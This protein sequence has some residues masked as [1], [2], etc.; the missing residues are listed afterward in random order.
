MLPISGRSE[1]P[2]DV[3]PDYSEAVLAYHSKHYD[4]ALDILNRLAQRLP[5]TIEI[6]ELKALISEFEKTYIQLIES[7]R[8]QG[9]P[10]NDVAPYFF[11]LGM[12]HYRAK[13]YDSAQ[14]ALIFSLKHGFNAPIAH[15]YLGIIATIQSDFN[16]A[17]AHFREVFRQDENAEI[18]PIAHFYQAQVCLK[19]GR[20]GDAV[21]R[22][23]LAKESAKNIINDARYPEES[24]NISRAILTASEKVLLPLDRGEPFANALL[25]AGFDS[26]PIFLPTQINTAADLNQR[27]TFKTSA[28]WSGGYMTSPLRRIQLVPSIRGSINRNFTETTRGLEFVH[29]G[30]S[31]YINHRPLAPVSFGL[32]G[33]FSILFK[34]DYTSVTPKTKYALFNHMIS[35]GPYL[36]IEPIKNLVMGAEFF[37]QPQKF[38]QDIDLDNART[39]TDWIGRT[40]IQ[41][42]HGHRV[43]NPQLSVR[44]DINSTQGKNF[45]SKTL[46][47]TVSNLMHLTPK[48]NANLSADF[49]QSGYKDRVPEARIDQ[50]I[51]LSSTNTYK[52]AQHWS[53]LWL[54]DWTQNVSNLPDIFSYQR[55]T[56]QSGISYSL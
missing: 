44:Y 48:L 4:Q 16:L 25:L 51:S 52:L 23:S 37:G 11:A 54:M 40:W 18:F 24:K 46:G 45:R 31:L 3:E 26:N 29:H 32:K 21:R 5:K 36:R 33:D 34:N 19:S 6:L 35:I 49:Y 17:E 28:T 53:L 27:Q 43:L 41:Y 1:I 9:A 14:Q 38:Y 10:E 55:F 42:D 20:M 8:E 7:K 39:G 15:L 30:A 22:L 2:A 12:I 47:A 56:V 13:S 50:G